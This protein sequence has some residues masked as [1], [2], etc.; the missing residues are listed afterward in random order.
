MAKLSVEQKTI[1]LLFEDKRADFLVPSYQRPYAWEDVECLQLWADVVE[2]AFP[3]DNS[4]K[5]NPQSDEFFLGPIVTFENKDKKM[6]IID[7]Q[8]RLT[9]LML[10]LRA[11]YEKFANMHD[12]QNRKVYETIGSCIWKTDEEGEPDKEALKIDSQVASDDDKEEFLTI[13]RTGIADENQK[14]KYADN[15]RL[16]QSKIDNFVNERPDYF[17]LLVLRLLNNCV[18]LPIEATSQDYAL[19]I[20]STLND[21]GKPLADADIFKAQLYEF[22]SGMGRKDEFISEWKELEELCSR[23]F[24]PKNATPMDE[25]FTRY[26]YFERAK[27]GN[28]SSS[29]EALRKFYE[30]DRYA[31]LKNTETFEN[32]KV[33]ADFWDDV[34]NQNA[35]R[36][37]DYV[38]RRLFVLNNAPNNM[39]TF[40]VSV[41]FMAN[42]DVQGHLDDDLFY[43]FLDKTTAFIWAYS[44]TNPGINALRTPIFTEMLNIVEGKPVE[45]NEFKFEIEAIKNA[46]SNYEFTNSKQ[47]TKSMLAWWAFYDSANTHVDYVE[48]D[49]AKNYEEGVVS[50]NLE[51]ELLSIETKFEIEHIFSRN[52][53]KLEGLLKSEKTLELLGNKVL[54]EKKINIRA[55]D[56]RF[57]DKKKHYRKSKIAELVEFSYDSGTQDFVETDIIRR[58]N[59]ILEGFVQYLK[60]TNLLKANVHTLT[61]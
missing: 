30:K 2:F 35:D 1:R 53:Q 7:G 60:D 59:D 19:R 45:F 9:T 58:N 34:S 32:L 25:L 15:F 27:L 55:S 8:Q 36:F 10:L 48:G 37:S 50:E 41:Y 18:L 28:K 16:L 42:K 23:I 13:L 29:T 6:E 21:R 24:N 17:R 40:F 44:R 31:L 43:I 3:D 26:M 61:T 5:F 51:Q 38:L 39:W 52:R 47:I 22:Y 11:F 12:E 46:F 20:F 33:L 54:L 14:S 49:A 4:E 56:Y 57:A